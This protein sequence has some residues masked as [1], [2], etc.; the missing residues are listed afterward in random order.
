MREFNDKDRA[1]KSQRLQLG[2]NPANLPAETLTD[3]ESAVTSA[4]E[5]GCLPC[6]VGWRVADKL[7]VPRISV[8]AVL[9]KLGVR[10]ANCQ[11]GFFR[12]EKTPHQDQRLVEL[13]SEIANALRDLNAARNLTCTTAFELTRRFKTTP[14]KVSAAAS[15][16]KLKIGNCQ[17]GCF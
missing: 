6:P 17:L 14:I 7:G 3:L 11:L 2:E 1:K 15:S 5:D 16:L 8:G 4:L 10:V 13:S 9:D 12:V